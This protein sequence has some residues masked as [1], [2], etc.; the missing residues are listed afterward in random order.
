M[1]GSI[2]EEYRFKI[3]RK[4]MV[5]DLAAR[6][7]LTDPRLIHAFSKIPRHAFVNDAFRDMAYQDQSLPIGFGQTISHPSTVAY[8]TSLLKLEKHHRVLEVGTG[9][10]Y[11]TA[12]LAELAG[13]VYSVEIRAE[14]VR[15]SQEIIEKLGYFTVRIQQGDGSMGLRD[16][17]PFDRIIVTAGSPTVP[18][19]LCEQLAPGGILV[20]PVGNRDSQKITVVTAS[21]SQFHIQKFG[22]CKFVE[23][24]GKNGWPA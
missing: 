19:A 14:L 13:K 22:T 12:I 5:S 23:L 17:A 4:Q 15:F 6:E 3:A 9:C 21:D 16:P 18:E 2:Q 11:Q 24:I 8:M 1:A 7:I 10:G 20:I